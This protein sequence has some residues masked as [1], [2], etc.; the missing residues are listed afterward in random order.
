MERMNGLERIKTALKL[1]DADRVPHFERV[2][3]TVRD[4]ILPGASVEDFIEHMDL[5][6][7][8]FKGGR[9]GIAGS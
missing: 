6:G 1:K 2:A 7:I 5:D 3:K 8:R 9:Q 4:A